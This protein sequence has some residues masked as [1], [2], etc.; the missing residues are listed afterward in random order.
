MRGAREVTGEPF[1]CGESPFRMKGLVY[2]A[3]KEC[4]DELIPDG[5]AAVLAHMESGTLREFFGQTF[6][7][8]AWY[9]ALPLVRVSAVAA[10][11]AGKTHAQLIRGNAAW[12]AARDVR[13]VYKF[14]LQLA[15]ADLVAQRLGR[16]SMQ[17]FDFG[18]AEG[19]IIRPKVLESYR[20][21]I[22]APMAQWFIHAAE[23]FTPVALELTGAR[24]VR[25]RSWSP[26]PDGQVEG[27][28]TVRIRFEVSWA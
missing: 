20:F 28:T 13:G 8:G 9:D 22:P 14:L 1:A 21:G 10:R 7:P 17:Y 2:G 12:V 15:S 4:Y 5:S 18:G 11:V 26:K 25:V 16:V 19:S 6:L 24:N 3:A 23:G 27:M